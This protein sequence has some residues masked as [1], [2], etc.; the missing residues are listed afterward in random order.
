MT[1]KLVIQFARHPPILF[2]SLAE[3][4]APVLSAEIAVLLATDAVEQY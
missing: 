1:V 4:D 2:I 3:K